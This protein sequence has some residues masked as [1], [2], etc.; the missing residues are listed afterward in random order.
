MYRNIEDYSD[1]Y[2]NIEAERDLNG[3][4]E[5]ESCG[6]EILRLIGM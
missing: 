3:N 2:R 4:I 5:N 1:V 6:I